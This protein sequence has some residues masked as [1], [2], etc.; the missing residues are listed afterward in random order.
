MGMALGLTLLVACNTL[1]AEEAP[2]PQPKEESTV[3]K[4]TAEEGE[5]ICDPSTGPCITDPS[6]IQQNGAGL[7]VGPCVTDPTQTP[8]AI[9]GPAQE[10]Y[11]PKLR[12][13]V[14][15]EKKPWLVESAGLPPDHP[16]FRRGRMIWATSFLWTEAPELVVEEWVTDKP[17]LEGKYVLIECWATWC[18][19]CRRSLRL[20]NYYHN[21]YKDELAVIA[22]C[23]TDREALRKMEDPLQLEDIDFHL[24]VD[25]Q[26]RFAD[27]LGVFGIPHAVIIEPQHGVVIWEGMPTLPGYELSEDIIERMLAIGRQLKKQQTEKEAK[28]NASDSSPSPQ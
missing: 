11:D 7:Q 28:E 19:P 27:A 3:E 13:Q 20:L 10:D 4:N 21:K 5:E 18:P 16:A 17:E 24:A 15:L 22:V 14:D 25:T 23:E 6:K 8:R 26:R 1:L 2:A 12:S 9:E